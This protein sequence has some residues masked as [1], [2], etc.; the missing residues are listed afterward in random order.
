M[1][2]KSL[3]SVVQKRRFDLV[4]LESLAAE[5]EE[6]KQIT[7]V[8]MGSV[9]LYSDDDCKEICSQYTLKYQSS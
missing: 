8:R 7:S 1:F 9:K 5:M 4:K 2:M 6:N 3:N